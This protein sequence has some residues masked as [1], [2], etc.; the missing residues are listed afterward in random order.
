MK[1][2]DRGRR[3]EG[4]EKVGIDKQRKQRGGSVARKIKAGRSEDNEK[5]GKTKQRR[6]RK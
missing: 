2:K 5:T 3:K 1:K 4:R 6:E